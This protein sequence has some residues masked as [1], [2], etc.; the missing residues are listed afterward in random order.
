MIGFAI[1]L[2]AGA[3][4]AVRAALAHLARTMT[5]IG[6]PLPRAGATDRKSVV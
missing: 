3:A 1:A 6:Q 5:R 2:S 4:I